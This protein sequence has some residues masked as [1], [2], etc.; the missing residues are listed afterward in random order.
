MNFV[1]DVDLPSSRSSKGC[2]TDEISHCVD[3]IVRGGIHFVDVEA[4]T[5]LD[6]NARIAGAV[7]FAIV[8]RIFAIERF[9][10]NAG[11]RSLSRSSGAAEK[12]GMTDFLLRYGVSE[13]QDD[14]ILTK[15]LGKPLRSIAPV[16][17][18]IRNFFHPVSV[19]LFSDDPE[20]PK[21]EEREVPPFGQGPK[22]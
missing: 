11:H 4:G 8:G 16:Q 14:V 21:L 3:A 19:N 20:P 13:G 17:G 7:G 18:L 12:V 1:D 2:S 10:Q 9:G 15:D 22:P 6:A 5:L